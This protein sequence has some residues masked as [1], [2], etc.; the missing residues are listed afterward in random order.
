L[1]DYEQGFQGN[2]NIRGPGR[3]IEYTEA[4]QLEYVKCAQDPEYFISHYVKIKNVD[5]EELILFKPRPYQSEMVHKMLHERNVIVKLPRQAG[6]TSIVAACLLW[7]IIFNLNYSILIAAHVGDK[8][9]DVLTT[10]RQM[11]EELPEFLQ[12]GVKKWNEGRIELETGSR[13][14]AGS[15][16]ARSARGDTYNMVYMDEFAFVETHV[17]DEFVKSVIPT[18]SSGATTKIFITS[19]PRGLNMFYNMWRAAV[20][21]KSGYA[22]VEIK[23]NDVP[24]RDEKFRSEII[25]QYGKTFFDQEFGAEFLGSSLTLIDSGKLMEI[26]KEDPLHQTENLRVYQYPEKGMQYCIC[27]DVSEGLGQDATAA[28]VFDI[29]A[30]PYKVVAVYHNRYIEP[31]NLPIVLKSLGDQYNKAMVLVEANFGSQVADILYHDMDYEQVVSTARSARKGDRVNGGFAPNSRR[32]LVM[33]QLP[34]RIGC[35]NLKTLIE[36]DQ[37]FV[38]DEAIYNELCRF[39]VKGRSYEAESGNDDL[40]MCL[41]MFAWLVDQGYIRDTTDV[42]LRARI[43]ELNEERAWNT[44]APFGYSDGSEEEVE[45]I[46]MTPVNRADAHVAR[47]NTMF[48]KDV[49]RGGRDVQEMEQLFRK[50]FMVDSRDTD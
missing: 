3:K 47:V 31:M 36:Q 50:S 24:G 23:W 13:I 39:A 26:V 7:H 21:G 48:E 46:N 18:V 33:S 9:R 8:A 35:A 5:E 37:L 22:H 27:V 28:V 42:N 25:S 44:I 14:K 29:T 6:K 34:K 32:G 11:Y 20:E 49:A 2:Q 38:V 4:Q 40:V 41:V 19:T 30:L 15:T 17:A 45:A 10:V 1:A 12:H 16:T 43:H